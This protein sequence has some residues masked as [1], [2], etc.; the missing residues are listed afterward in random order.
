VIEEA[1]ETIS[2]G[3][4]KLRLPAHILDKT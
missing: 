4:V 1:G 3:S 2:E